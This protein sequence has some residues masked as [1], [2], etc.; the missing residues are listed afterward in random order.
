MTLQQGLE[1]LAV[2]APD[3]V[4]IE[5]KLSIRTEVETFMIYSGDRL[6]W[7]KPTSS[8]LLD[9]YDEWSLFGA[10]CGYCEEQNW[11]YALN[12][13]DGKS[14]F[15]IFLPSM[16]ESEYLESDATAAVLALVQ[17][18]E[19]QVEDRL[20]IEDSKAALE[21]AEIYGT[22]SHENLKAEL[23][24]E[25][26]PECENGTVFNVRGDLGIKC[27]TCNGTGKKKQAV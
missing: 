27:K 8:V 6:L 23:D 10:V 16:I 13:V 26:C 1:R 17:A 4:R 15:R 12:R 11:D 24:L 3:F 18:L 19:K 21:E 20:D 22:I 5:N 2:L 14:K 9:F 25:D 7:T